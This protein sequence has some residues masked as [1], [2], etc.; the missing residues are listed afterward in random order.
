MVNY[1]MRFLPH[2]SDIC[3][4]IRT[5]TH[6][7]VIFKW[8]AVYDKAFAELKSAITSAPFLAYFDPSNKNLVIQCEAS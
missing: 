2:V 8:S 7:D 3:E 5:L 6:K 1:L 4:L